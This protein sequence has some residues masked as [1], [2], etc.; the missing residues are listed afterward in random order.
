MTVT[1]VV[2]LVLMIPEHL[3]LNLSNFSMNFYA[4]S[5]FA[6]FS[7]C[8]FCRLTPG[9]LVSFKGRSLAE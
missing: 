4:F 8:H 6:F 7:S 9:T 3:D 1:N 5:K 2:V